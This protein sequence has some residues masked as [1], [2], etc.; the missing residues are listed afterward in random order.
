MDPN[1]DINL[2]AFYKDL[3]LLQQ[4]NDE[5]TPV[6][7]PTWK[8]I[9]ESNVD[10][11]SEMRP[12]F[13]LLAYLLCRRTT[14]GNVSAVGIIE[15]TLIWT[16]N[17]N[18][19]QYSK[20]QLKK[21]NLLQ[22]LT[23]EEYSR[24]FFEYSLGIIHH[25]SDISRCDSFKE[26][27][28]T[29]HSHRIRKQIDNHKKCLQQLEQTP[30]VQECQ[31][32]LKL[33]E[34]STDKTYDEYLILAISAL[35][36]LTVFKLLPQASMT[37]ET[38]FELRNLKK[39]ASYMKRSDQYLR[40]LQNPLNKKKLLQVEAFVYMPAGVSTKKAKT[41]AEMHILDFLVTKQQPTPY[42]IGI[43]KDSC[44]LCEKVLSH[45]KTDTRKGHQR[46]YQQWILPDFLSDN[47]KAI[48][49]QEIQ[50][51]AKS[52]RD[53]QKKRKQLVHSSPPSND[54]ESEYSQLKQRLL[55][56]R[57]QLA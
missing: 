17:S 53:N 31:I 56:K 46:P 51:E 7:P 4:H 21:Q 32:Y 38:L 52:L 13:D 39:L 8:E 24:F 6:I 12:F 16:Q 48:V 19:P 37:F 45:F 18:M 42:V 25:P 35:E 41:H 1:T 57:K 3:A 36:S 5:L 27:L 14:E 34:E 55:K 40:C 15:K 47:I 20:T 54:N 26:W 11:T 28:Y 30:S 33:W 44:Y 10:T 23:D 9:F 50:F 22:P 2:E 49:V 43:S 29:Q